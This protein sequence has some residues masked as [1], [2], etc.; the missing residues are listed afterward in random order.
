MKIAL[1]A[2]M[3]CISPQRCV[4][5]YNFN[6]TTGAQPVASSNAASIDIHYRIHQ[7]GQPSCICIKALLSLEP[8]DQTFSVAQACD[9]EM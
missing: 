4:S 8:F 9:L 2:V 3:C 6:F 5:G 7:A 1:L